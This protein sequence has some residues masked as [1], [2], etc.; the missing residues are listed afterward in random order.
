[1]ADASSASSRI[2]RA[3]EDF[4]SGIT[5]PADSV[6][7]VVR[8]SWARSV[9]KGVDPAEVTPDHHSDPTM[10]HQEFLSYRE[11]HPISAVRPLVQSLMLDDISDSQVVVALTDQ[12]GRLLWVEGPSSARDKAGAINFL[13]GSIWSEDVVGTNAPGLALS[14]GRGVQVI[15]PEH[16]AESVQGW[17]CA[18]APVHDPVTGHVIGGGRS[19]ARITVARRRS[20]STPERLRNERAASDRARHRRIPVAGGR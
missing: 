8:D 19:G 18:A 12:Q 15:G 4:R 7:S 9:R 14:V 1:M 11:A 2:R 10:T 13:E 5:P 20:R 16:F 17:S 6:R 3:Y